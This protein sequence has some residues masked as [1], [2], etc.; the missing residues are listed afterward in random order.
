MKPARGGIAGPD[1]GSRTLADG[2][3]GFNS[4]NE[5]D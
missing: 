4:F 1:Q 2:L 5:K 3:G